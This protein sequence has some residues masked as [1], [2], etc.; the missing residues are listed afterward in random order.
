[1]GSLGLLLILVVVAAIG[2]N[3]SC[4][5]KTASDPELQVK[6]G[7]GISQE[8][9]RQRAR[10]LIVR[11]CGDIHSHLNIYVDAHGTGESILAELKDHLIGY[12]SADHYLITHCQKREADLRDALLVLSCYWNYRATLVEAE[13]NNLMANS[14]WDGMAQLPPKL[15]FRLSELAK[16][17]D[18]P[19]KQGK[20][21]KEQ[22]EQEQLNADREL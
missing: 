15:E 20:I 12:R 17:L 14:T 22:L 19:M 1:M 7:K 5:E 13:K 21:A 10:R 6:R 16:I 3:K 11:H 4:G 8:L 2:E 9:L 18:C